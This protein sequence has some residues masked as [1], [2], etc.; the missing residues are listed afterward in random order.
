MSLPQQKFREIVFQML[1]SYDLGKAKDED[2]VPLLMAELSVTKKAVLNAQERVNL[3]QEKQ[4]EIDLLIAK[5]SLSYSFERIQSVE[6]N[7]LRLGV[8]ELLYDDEIPPKV[9][10]AE[11]LRLARKFGSPESASF[12]NAILDNFYKESLGEQADTVM[13][14]KAIDNLA[15]SE[16]IAK[17]ASLQ[18]PKPETAEE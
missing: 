5:K 8:Y 6:R 2:M 3:I 7:V 14:S 13:I 15:K 16:E 18:P 17:E 4:P 1:Y 11:A 9:A 10:I 12:V